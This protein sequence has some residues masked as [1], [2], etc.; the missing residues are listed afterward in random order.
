V[1]RADPPSKL[2]RVLG[3]RIPRAPRP[4]TGRKATLGDVVL[5]YLREQRDAIRTN[6]PEV[7][8]ELPD[9]V[10]HMRVAT[11]RMRSALQ[12][13]GRVVDRGHTRALTEELK[14]LAGVL[15]DARDLEVLQARITTALDAVPDDLLLGPV[16]AQVTRYFAGREAAARTALLEA[17]DGERY[18][19]L[20]TAIEDLIAAPP[21][22]RAARERARDRL[23]AIVGR[24]HRRVAGHVRA[25][26]AL[27]R[28]HRRDTELHE[29]RK[30]AKRLRYATE[31]AEP[32]LGGPATRLIK[33][34]KNVQELLGDH[35]DSTVARPVLRELA[36]QAQLDGVNGFTF[37][38]LHARESAHLPDTA[39]GRAWP[40]LAKAARAVAKR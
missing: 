30:A 38:L 29:A 21:L 11:R 16:R 9:S 19:A 13:Y 24:A 37:G 25:A 40:K 36:V 32:V 17:L 8:R 3:G 1:R 35:Q 34:T 20:L 27:P 28:G 18:L 6:D 5:G 14:W 2:A 33:R 31:A 26:E 23:G 12:A 7:R 39:L 4:R 22:T 15:G 10:H